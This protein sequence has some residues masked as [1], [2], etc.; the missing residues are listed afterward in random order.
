ML[1]SPKPITLELH[2]Q[3]FRRMKNNKF[4]ILNNVHIDGCLEYLPNSLV[5]L[6]LSHCSFSLPSNVTMAYVL[7]FPKYLT[8]FAKL[9]VIAKKIAKWKQVEVRY[10]MSFAHRVAFLIGSFQAPG[11]EIPDE[12]NHQSD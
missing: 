2:A 10:Q 1:Y 5:L 8:R 4:L 11:S 6:E 9:Q 3:A 7:P 12:F